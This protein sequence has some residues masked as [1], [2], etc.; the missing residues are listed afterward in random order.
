MHGSGS[1]QACTCHMVQS[2]TMGQFQMLL[3]RFQWKAY[4][5]ALAAGKLHIGC[6]VHQAVSKHARGTW[7][8]P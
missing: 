8:N 1:K 5:Q 3:S 4:M 2:V 7:Y 6:H